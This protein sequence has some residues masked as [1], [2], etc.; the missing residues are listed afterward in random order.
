M[1]VL[2]HTSECLAIQERLIGIWLLSLAS[3]GVGIFM[4]FLF[5]PPVDV[6]GAFCIALGCVF[7]TLTPSETFIFDKRNGC[8]T[9]HKRQ[10]LRQQ[11]RALS[12][13]DIQ[14]V[15]VD[16]Q[17]FLGAQFYQI[18][19]QLAS[20]ESLKVTKTVTTDLQQQ[21]RIVRHIRGFLSITATV[22]GELLQPTRPI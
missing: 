18:K 21:Q 9:A 17:E 16:S 8:L 12:I 14:A 20:G 22:Q 5:E 3:I 6:V 7:A 19:L 1:K 10:I 13:K 2:Q 15:Q 4:F 11:T